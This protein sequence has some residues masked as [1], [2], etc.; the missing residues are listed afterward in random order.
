MGLFVE[1][2]TLPLAP[3]RGVGW[4]V[5]KIR[6][7][8][9]QEL[10]DPTA[11]QEELASLERAHEEGRIEEQEFRQREDALLAQLMATRQQQPPH[12]L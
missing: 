7:A 10:N 11:L 1:L 8:A 12:G 3:V 4:V 5:D 2:L 9:E 6:L